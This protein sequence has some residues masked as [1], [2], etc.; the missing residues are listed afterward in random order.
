MDFCKG[1]QSTS[2]SGTSHFGFSH[3]WDWRDPILS[4]LA[5]LSPFS[6][7]D[8]RRTGETQSFQAP[9][10]PKDWRD[11]VLSAPHVPLGLARL[12]PF[13]PPGILG[14]SGTQSFQPL[15]YPGDRV[16]QK[17]WYW[18]VIDLSPED[19]YGYPGKCAHDT[20]RARFICVYT[21]AASQRRF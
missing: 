3:P 15:K 4:G 14:A 11:S 10:Y 19:W 1:R 17:D 13:S 2:P 8:T 9:R 7:P 16:R 12:S 18:R 20:F 6:H 21:L 5:G